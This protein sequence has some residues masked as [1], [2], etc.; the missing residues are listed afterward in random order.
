ML[1]TYHGYLFDPTD[2]KHKIN[3]ARL[4]ISETKILVEIPKNLSLLRIEVL[5]G[6]FIDFGSS[7]TLLHCAF[8]SQSIS[9]NGAVIT[10]YVVLYLFSGGSFNNSSDINFPRVYVEIPALSEFF[11]KSLI[12]Q[13]FLDGGKIITIKNPEDVELVELEDF[14]LFLSLGYKT[15]RKLDSIAINETFSLKIISN[16]QSI[17]FLEYLKIIEHFQSFLLLILNC[18]PD[19]TKITFYEDDYSCVDMGRKVSR[20]I[21]FFTDFNRV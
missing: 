10:R 7:V 2:S 17:N 6:A 3:G 19:I 12:K 20:S 8:H 13:E 9:G 18:S 11:K 14:S 15:N 4:K 5:T 21:N 1:N 16:N